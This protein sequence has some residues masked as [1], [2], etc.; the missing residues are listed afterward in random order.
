MDV[1]RTVRPLALACLIYSA[2]MLVLAWVAVLSSSDA[3]LYVASV[4]AATLAMVLLVFGYMKRKLWLMLTGVI[5]VLLFCPSPLGLWPLFAGF[6]LVIVF[7]FIAIKVKE[8][9]GKLW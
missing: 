9:Y 7:A 3:R 5:A 1:E 6:M 8:D 4:I 2:L